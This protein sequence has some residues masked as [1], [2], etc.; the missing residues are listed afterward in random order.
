MIYE[1]PDV[2]YVAT[3]AYEKHDAQTFGPQNRPL[4]PDPGVRRGKLP[5]L[6][7][8][9]THAACKPWKHSMRTRQRQPRERETHTQVSVPFSLV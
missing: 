7:V 2:R 9:S 4:D 8:C 5:T 6:Y 3:V 1:L